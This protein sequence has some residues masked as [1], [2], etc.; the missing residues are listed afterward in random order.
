MAFVGQ[1]VLATATVATGVESIKESKKAREATQ[2]AAASQRQQ[3]RAQAAESRRRAYREVQA[4]RA[5]ARAQ[6]Q[7]LGA[8]GG[9]GV[10]G[11][12]SSLSSQFGSALGFGSQMS[13]LSQDIN[14]FQAQAASA[15]ARSEMFGSLSGTLGNLGGYGTISDA[16]QGKFP[17]RTP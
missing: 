2:R 5:Q 10:A 4:K 15:Q 3:Q 9:S 6:A 14:M 16:F 7:A 12:I 11:G 8:T 13:G 1:V 17:T